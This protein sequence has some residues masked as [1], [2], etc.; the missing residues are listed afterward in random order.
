MKTPNSHSPAHRLSPQAATI[1]NQYLMPI[2]Q[3]QYCFDR[4]EGVY[5]FDEAG[6]RYLDLIGGIAT[7][8][9][10]HGNQG[11]VR[12]IAKQAAQMINTSNLFYSSPQAMLAEKLCTLAGM[13]KCF[14]CNSGTE[15]NEAAIKLARKHTK[16]KKIITL[17]NG[18]HGRTLGSLSA[19]WNPAYRKGFGLLVPGF[20]HV[21]TNDT[22]QLLTMADDQTAA[23]MIE[24]I[25][26]EAGVLPLSEEYLD[27][28][29]QLCRDRGILLI[30]DEVQTGN[31]RTGKY[32]AWQHHRLYPDIVTTAKGLANGI[33]IGVMLAR[34]GLTFQIKEHGS[35]FGGNN[36]ACAAAIET[37]FQVEKL[38]P[39]VSA[40][41][42]Y[43]AK[44]IQQIESGKIR[45]VRGMG[46]M[47]A[48]VLKQKQP[49]LTTLCKET[50]IIVNVINDQIIR[51]LPPLTISR[52][53]IDFAVEMLARVLNEDEK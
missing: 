11:V 48:I 1:D 17:I 34:K 29:Q 31:G 50:G 45:E 36:L 51:L 28:I 39:E 10:G 25:Q 7:C 47:L 26:G 20:L 22:D 5:L 15:A 8:T 40:N 24:V 46:L 43:F 6:N 9:V 41:G 14:L 44:K 12:A 2:Y 49:N 27:L 19:T 30:I 38:L 4:G 42:T 33:P 37:L 52:K 13:D 16:K 3:K 32:F 21:D 35:T 18:F 53:E 23:I